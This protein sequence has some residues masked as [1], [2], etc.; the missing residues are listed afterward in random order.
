M[1]VDDWPDLR[2]ALELQLRVR[3]YKYWERRRE[4]RK[5]CLKEWARR[6]QARL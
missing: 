6:R 5:K 1:G 2:P 4:P 3:K